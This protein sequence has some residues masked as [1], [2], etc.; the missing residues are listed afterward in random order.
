[1]RDGTRNERS[2]SVCSKLASTR[3]IDIYLI[4]GFDLARSVH[5][6]RHLSINKPLI[7]ASDFRVALAEAP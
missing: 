4:Q 5:T 2:E 6:I 7:W 3:L 1:M